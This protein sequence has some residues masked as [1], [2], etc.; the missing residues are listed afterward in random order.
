MEHD[1]LEQQRQQ[2]DRKLAEAERK[3]EEQAA[4][5]RRE[6]EE[7]QQQADMVAHFVVERFADEVRPLGLIF[8]AS[9][10]LR[11][12]NDGVRSAQPGAA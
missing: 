5:H 4:R 6:E 12:T 10:L 7:R 11:S 2:V 3:Q 8:E 1:E 9:S